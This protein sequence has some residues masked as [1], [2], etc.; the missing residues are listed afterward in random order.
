MSHSDFALLNSYE[1]WEQELD[2]LVVAADAACH[3]TSTQNERQTARQDLIEYRESCPFGDLKDR[4][5][6]SLNDLSLAEIGNTL[7]HLQGLQRQI[8]SRQA[9]PQMMAPVG[10]P[11]TRHMPD[12]NETMTSK[13]NQTQAVAQQIRELG[14]T[15][16]QVLE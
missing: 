14:Q 16:Q 6:E 5:L 15:L 4:A 13:T 1:E 9:S 8:K 10:Q 2:T 7:D 3:P 12:T 11:Q